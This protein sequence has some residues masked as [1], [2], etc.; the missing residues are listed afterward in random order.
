MVE[1]GE[2]FK[3]SEQ[4]GNTKKNDRGQNHKPN[5][6]STND[7]RLTNSFSSL[8]MVTDDEV[9]I[10]MKSLRVTNKW[11]ALLLLRLLMINIASWNIRGLNFSPKQSKVRHVISENNLSICAILESHVLDSNLQRL[12]SLVFR[13]W[14]WTSNGSSCSKG[15]RI[16]LGWNHNEVDVAVIN[17]DDQCIHTRCLC[18]HKV[19]V[20]D[21]PWCLLGDF[22]SAL[23]LEDSTAGSSCIDISMREFKDC[24]E[25]I[26]VMDVQSL[27]LQ[28]TWSQKPK[29]KDGIIK[30]IDRIMANMEFNDVFVGAHAIFKLYHVSD[31][32]P[33]V[34]YI[35]PLAKLD[36]SIQTDLDA[37]PFNVDLRESE[38]NSVGA[39]NE[40]LIMEDHFLKQKAKMRIG[41][42]KGDSN[43]AYFF[44]AFK[45]R[46]S[47]SHIDVMTC[48]DGTI[49]ENENV[50]EAFVSHYELYP[51]SFLGQSRCAFKVN[52]QKAYDTVDWGFLKEVRWGTSGV[53]PLSPLLLPLCHGDPYVCAQRPGKSKV[54]WEIVCLPMDEGGLGV[55][56]L[57][58][59]NKAL[60][61]S[62]VWKLLS[63]KESL[64]VKWIHAYKLKGRS[65]WDYPL[66]G[67]MSWGWRKVLQLRPLIRD[68]IRFSI[69]DGAYSHDVWH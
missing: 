47:R 60:M 38:A 42:Q 46:V 69:G 68:F 22:N 34:A 56:R 37:D 44:K 57:D 36:V 21:R 14:D 27:G 31:H 53:T 61:V 55:R 20:R 6:K 50:A 2:S 62:H 41:L 66:R 49:V 52:I 10:G 63:L 35:P 23:L 33:S 29:G 28:F 39:L 18:L 7:V 24:V 17:Q 54:A 5:V 25:E 43:S 9:L 59:F 19:Y 3:A 1:K 48:A 8:G 40:A 12:C 30:K 58:T 45:S 16:I 67:N 11:Q 4:G 51:W 26:E 32:S 15:T 65:F 13:H 64:W